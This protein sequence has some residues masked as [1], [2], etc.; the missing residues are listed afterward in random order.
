[1]AE[2]FRLVN[3]SNLP[4]STW[5]V[6]GVKLYTFV[7]W[8]SLRWKVQVLYKV[9]WL[10]SPTP[11]W[12]NHVRLDGLKIGQHPAGPIGV[13]IAKRLWLHGGKESARKNN[14]AISEIW[15]GY[16]WLP[17]VVVVVVVVVVAAC[18]ATSS[19]HHFFSHYSFSCEKTR[20]IRLQRQG[21]AN[22]RPF[23]SPRTWRTSV[24]ADGWWFGHGG[25]HNN[26]L[27]VK[28]EG[29]V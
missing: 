13:L 27:L 6:K 25:W 9:P 11:F 22:C 28:L 24:S 21:W 14:G 1:M 4:R 15:H 29:P 19:K 26:V 18:Q 5:P 23:K 7:H 12:V 2:L 10:Q 16:F 3:Y 8:E 17:I 20:V